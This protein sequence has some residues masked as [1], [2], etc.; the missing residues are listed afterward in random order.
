M[1]V[2]AADPVSVLKESLRSQLH[3]ALQVLAKK[4]VCILPPASPEFT[5]L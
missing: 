4:E 1:A 5:H 3:G 2:K